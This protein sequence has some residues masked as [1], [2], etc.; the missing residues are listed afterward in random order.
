[1]VKNIICR[2]EK[3]SKIARIYERRVIGYMI[4]KAYRK[5]VRFV[6]RLMRIIR[7]DLYDFENEDG[8]GSFEPYDYLTFYSNLHAIKIGPDFAMFHHIENIDKELSHPRYIQYILDNNR[9]SRIKAF[10]DELDE[11]MAAQ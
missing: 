4:F 11:Y 5:R 3:F 10:D 8:Y 7:F 2:C 9:E 6:E 1:M